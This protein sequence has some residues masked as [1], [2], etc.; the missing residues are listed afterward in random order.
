LLRRTLLLLVPAAL[1]L[2][3]CGD[4]EPTSSTSATAD[5]SALDE[6]D[7]TPGRDGAAPTLEFETPFAIETTAVRV[8]AEGDGEA[9]AEGDLAI[10]DFLILNGADASEIG[11]SYDIDPAEVI[12]NGELLKGLH[13][14]LLDLPAGSQ[15]LVGL[16][17][18]EGPSA[19]GGAETTTLLYIDLVDVRRPLSRAEGTSVERAA[20]LP[21][22]ELG[23]DG[24]PTITLPATDPPVDLVAQLLIEG[25][26]AA[27]ET[28][29]TVIVHYT[30]VQWDTG[31]VFDSSWPDS[32]ASF[33][34]GTGDVIPG[35]DK[36]L[37]GQPVGSQVLL[38][39][40]PADGYPEGNETIPAGATLV[41]V[42]DIL[43][44][45]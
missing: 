4:D 29:Q 3:A 27:V 32:P 13:D 36:G 15:A 14:A 12:V 31:A 21:S 40:P 1:L 9:T 16:P 24:E 22:V 34:I 18:G 5:A 38:I 44:A 23:A 7:V 8:L 35:W 6:I 19:D 30:G 10:F 28:G 43:E 39:V 41:F 33:P 26:G 42:V 2:G 25:K 45:H 37:V 17:A 11:S 20:G